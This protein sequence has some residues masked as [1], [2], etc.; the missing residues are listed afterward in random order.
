MTTD[1]GET[2]NIEKSTN[3]VVSSAKRD[4]PSETSALSRS[5]SALTG[6]ATQVSH[7]Q[8]DTA[9]LSTLALEANAFANAV[10]EFKSATNA[11]C[12]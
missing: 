7:G 6:T 3:A 1:A 12:S 2:H 10:D 9:T 11:K 4:F 5:Y 8:K